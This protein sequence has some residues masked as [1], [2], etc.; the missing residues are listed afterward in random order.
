MHWCSIIHC[1]QCLGLVIVKSMRA[2]CRCI[3]AKWENWCW[4][5]LGMGLFHRWTLACSWHSMQF[6]LIGSI[7]HSCARQG[8][9]KREQGQVNLSCAGWV[10][11][12]D[13]WFDCWVDW[14][15]GCSLSWSP[16]LSCSLLIDCVLVYVC[17]CCRMDFVFGMG[18]V[19]FNF[20]AGNLNRNCWETESILWFVFAE[21]MWINSPILVLWYHVRNVESYGRM[22]NSIESM[23]SVHCN[24][25]ALYK[26]I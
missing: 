25:H 22:Y 6:A 3:S 7:G 23:N 14:L 1:L 9:W 13:C 21:G 20:N 16:C 26:V 8:A 10:S 19:G 17:C 2:P 12:V 18:F 24:V 4:C 15:I 5:L 11:R